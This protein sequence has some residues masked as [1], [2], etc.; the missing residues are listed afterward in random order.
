MSKTTIGKIEISIESVKHTRT[1]K[2][3]GGNF[4]S[5]TACVEWTG[6]IGGRDY[7]HDVEV[8]V[9][10]WYDTDDDNAEWA[11]WHEGARVIERCLGGTGNGDMRGTAIQFA[12][13]SES[14]E[15]GA[16]I[17]GMLREA[18]QSPE[19]VAYSD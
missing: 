6:S 1:N 4:L 19:L 5:G 14:E 2:E 16:A 8:P 9:G 12:F 7:R 18:A 3:E 17:C 15:L 11:S 13:A 10:C